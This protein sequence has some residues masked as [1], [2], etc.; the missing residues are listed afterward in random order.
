M[1]FT[2][3]TSVVSDPNWAKSLEVPERLAHST[4]RREFPLTP[5]GELAFLFQ[6]AFNRD[7]TARRP[8]SHE[9]EYASGLVALMAQHIA[10][11]GLF[12]GLFKFS[13]DDFRMLNLILMPTDIWPEVR[14]I[15]T[16]LEMI[17]ADRIVSEGF[18][19]SHLLKV[20]WTVG[21]GDSNGKPLQELLL[22]IGQL[23]AYVDGVVSII[24]EAY[25][26]SNCTKLSPRL[27]GGALALLAFTHVHGYCHD[28]PTS[29]RLASMVLE[30]E[31]VLCGHG[32]GNK[33]AA[34]LEYDLTSRLL[35]DLLIETAKQ[36]APFNTSQWIPSSTEAMDLA[37]AWLEGSIHPFANFRQHMQWFVEGNTSV[38]FSELYRRNGI[39]NFARLRT[40]RAEDPWELVRALAAPPEQVIAGRPVVLCAV[41][42]SDHN[43]AFMD[44]GGEFNELWQ[45]S[46]TQGWEMDFVEVRDVTELAL[47]LT[48]LE[49]CGSR[50]FLHLFGHG[51][52][53]SLDLSDQ[54]RGG[55]SSL[56]RRELWTD[57][58]SRELMD[59]IA[60]CVDSIVLHSC[61]SA[62]DTG[63]PD[64]KVSNL[65]EAVHRATGRKVTVTGLVT[66]SCFQHLTPRRDGGGRLVPEVKP[67]W[68]G[69][70]T[71]RAGS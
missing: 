30:R 63:K 53:E 43:S 7:E 52:R 8:S 4:A 29:L 59:V 9:V 62:S 57:K 34:P 10:S 38:L 27:L 5:L 26:G 56:L 35:G 24:I 1:S 20:Y 33:S 36:H 42:S 61:S 40:A 45:Q 2:A 67:V 21:Y 71:L 69:S 65:V 32:V 16:S 28:G 19:V 6:H 17:L 60:R 3:H 66:N 25:R 18:I 64:R 13:Q 22:N 55:P 46:L 31:A 11:E 47:Q 70:V 23:D 41:G 48:R 44:R 68:D 51:D 14:E 39:R 37:S 49:A 12:A 54:A 15:K 58:D 50:V